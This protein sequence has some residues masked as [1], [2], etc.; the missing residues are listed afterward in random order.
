MKF[1]VRVL[2]L[3]LGLEGIVDGFAHAAERYRVA[4]SVR[5]EIP[6]K[7]TPISVTID[8]SKLLKDVGSGQAFDPNSIEVWNRGLNERVPAA[9]G[10]EFAFG[11]TGPVEWVIVEPDQR[12]YEIRFEA[13]AVRPVR[14]ELESPA[15]IG[16]GDLLRYG[17][18]E[19]RPVAMP[20]PGTFCDLDDD[21]LPEL[22]GMWNYAYRPGWPWSSLVAYPGRRRGSSDQNG[23]KAALEFG[24]MVHLRSVSTEEGRPEMSGREGAG[25]YGHVDAGDLNR[26]GLVDL[27]VTH[28]GNG[29]AEFLINTGKREPTGMPILLSQGSVKV[30]GWEACRLVDFDGD[31]V[32]DLVVNGMLIENRNPKGWPFEGGEP[33]T[34]DAGRHPCFLD[35]DGDGR[36]DAV[37]LQGGEDVQPDFHRVAWRRNEGG[38]PPR[39]GEEQLLSGIDVE[40][41]TYVAA[42]KGTKQPTLLVQHN[43]FQEIS[44]FELESAAARKLTENQKQILNSKRDEDS[45]GRFVRVGRAESRS[46]VMGLSDQAWPCLCDWDEDGDIDLLVGGGYGWPRI[47]INQGTS[48]YPKFSEPELILSEGKPIRFVRN[49]LLGPPKNWHDMGYPYPVFVDWD[50]DGLSD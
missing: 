24:E 40:T 39:F 9:I 7:N 28:H 27:V 8:F 36:L 25:A 42:V 4:V 50:G 20:Y 35:V 33:V 1:V 18:D 16:V 26:D 22:I 12:E 15:R 41:V 10:E 29:T 23:E 6:Y 14:R 38:D 5:S 11:D 19:L 30:E 46:A 37:C 43:A 2:L 48:A 31:Q 47:L 3:V 32:L 21:G 44:L 13:Q 45:E 49:E 34:L 17:G